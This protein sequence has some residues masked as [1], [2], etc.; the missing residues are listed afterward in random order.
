MPTLAATLRTEIR[1]GAAVEVQKALRRLRRIQ[2]QVKA[3]RTSSRRHKRALSGIERGVHR[4]T[5]RLATRG[6]RA[7]ARAPA[8]GPRVPP[9]AIRALRRRLK[10][11]RVQFA[12]LVGVSP[13]SIFGW[14]TGR[15]VP[16]GGSRARLG[17]L[18]KAGP[19]AHQ[20]RARGGAA[21]GRRRRRRARA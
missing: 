15:T 4:L 2:K 12:K 18:K 8:R 7:G 9:R 6:S 16:R 21:R 10:L 17:E 20:G 19:R 11:T 5:D 1:G 14:E 3:L 13:G